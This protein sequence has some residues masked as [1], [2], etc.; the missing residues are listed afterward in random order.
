MKQLSLNRRTTSILAGVVVFLCNINAFADLQGTWVQHPAATLRSS[1]KESQVHKIIEG[2][3][4]V[5]FAVRGELMSRKESNTYCWANDFDPITLFRYEKS[6]PWSEANIHPLAQ[7]VETSSV[8]ADVVDYDP[9]TGILAVA[10]EDHSLDFVYDDGSVVSSQVLKG[11]SFPK[12]TSRPY[13][14]TFDREQPVAYVAGSFGIAIIDMK[15]GDLIRGIQ[16]DKEVS[17]AGRVG[18]YMII[19]A[20]T[21]NRSTYSTDTYIYPIDKVPSALTMPANGAANLQVLMPLDDLTFGALARGSSDTSSTLN[22]YTIEENGNLNYKTLVTGLTVDNGSSADYRHM[23]RTDG[24]AQNGEDGSYVIHSNSSLILLKK[25]GTTESISKSS[26]TSTEKAAKAGSLNGT[27]VWLYEYASNGQTDVSQRGFYSYDVIDGTWGGKTEIIAPNAPTASLLYYGEWNEKYGMLFRG[28]GS[29]INVQN[30]DMDR[31]CSYKDGKWTDFS[32]AARSKTYAAKGDRIAPTDAAKFIGTDPLDPDMVWGAANR[33]G[34]FR[35]DMSDPDNFLQIGASYYSGKNYPAKFPGYFSLFQ[36]QLDWDIMINFTNVDFDNNGNMWFIHYNYDGYIGDRE[37]D[38]MSDV[39]ENSYVPIYFLTPEERQEIK[40][41]GNDRSKLPDFQNR[42]LKIPRI[43]INDNSEVIAL[44]G[45]GNTTYLASNHGFVNVVNIYAFIYDHNGTPENPDD[46][47]WT[48][49][50]ELFDENGAKVEY[51]FQCGMYEDT[52]NGDLWL[53]TSSGPF[54]MNP[55]DILA[56][57][58]VCRRPDITRVKGVPSNGNPLECVEINRIASDN[59]GRKWLATNE[60]LYCINKEGDEILDIYKTEN[61]PIPSNEVY[62]VAISP[63]NVVFV[64]TSRGLVEFRPEGS[65]APVVSGAHLAIMPAAVT[66]EYNGFVTITGAESGSEYAV[67][68]EN[69]NQVADLGST[70][71]GLLQWDCKDNSGNRVT[72]GRYNVRRVSREE[73][74]PIVIL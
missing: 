57:R 19:F 26:L 52:S 61:S 41:I 39:V 11:A 62:G 54:I 63:D 36:S 69:G 8:V 58:K 56:G 6:L 51:T 10:N 73:S 17:W 72:M 25:D 32:Y 35:I 12:Q 47:R 50:D 40:K 22:L 45:P 4:Y 24:Y 29:R 66:P 55:S 28:I 33:G 71:E 70:T 59:L 15:S 46:D 53:M 20:G 13:S 31:F 74:N 23:F 43:K 67:Y 5:Y 68:D 16:T 18:D 38:Y 42:M 3:R 48:I 1:T 65:L 37:L 60:G 7:V 49:I 44:K 30:T 27:R 14:V 21:V 34:L 2:N 9:R 64:M